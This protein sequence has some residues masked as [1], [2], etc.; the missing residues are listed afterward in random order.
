MSEE[1]KIEPYLDM[2]RRD[3]IGKL[4]LLVAKA[5]QTQQI[6]REQRSRIKEQICNRAGYLRMVLEQQ[7]MRVVIAALVAIGEN[8]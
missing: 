3:E 8:A 6:T 2:L 7:D 4:L 1:K 5:F